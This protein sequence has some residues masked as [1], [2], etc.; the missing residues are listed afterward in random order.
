[1]W[2]KTLIAGFMAGLLAFTPAFSSITDQA[3]MELSAPSVIRGKDMTTLSGGGV[4][5]RI[6][7][8]TFRPF[9]IIPP[10]LRTGCGG[11]DATFGAFSY[12]NMEYL[13]QFLQNVLQ[14]APV[15]AFNL[16][17][18]TLCPQCEQL[19]QQLTAIANQINQ[20]G[21]TKCG[22]IQ[23][24]TSIGKH[25][26]NEAMGWKESSYGQVAP[27]QFGVLDKWLKA[28]IDFLNN[29][30]AGPL[31]QLCPQGNCVAG[32]MYRLTTQNGG[33]VSVVKFAVENEV[34]YAVRNLL[35]VDNYTLELIIRAYVGDVVIK[36]GTADNNMRS[37]SV[38]LF[39]PSETDTSKI[40]RDLLGMDITL[41][42]GGG[43]SADIN[44]CS[45]QG[46]I[47]NLRTAQFI[48]GCPDGQC[49][50]NLNL[51]NVRINS[52]CGQV[53][54]TFVKNIIQKAIN[55]QALSDQEKVLIASMPAPMMGL[56]N[57]GTVEPSI[58]EVAG[59]KMAKY[60]ATQLAIALIDGISRSLT[61][62][63]S[64]CL[65]EKVVSDQDK[66]ACMKFLDNVS[67][68]RRVMVRGQ[69][70]AMKEL[71]ESIATINQ[72]LDLQAKVMARISQSPLYGNFAFS[73]LVGG[74][75]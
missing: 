12:F 6:R 50:S 8:E 41:T 16:A 45:N 74:L 36:G 68:L 57:I 37:A 30:V 13:G 10:N 42:S 33:T 67:E 60:M 38:I 69:D 9:N 19:L 59:D 70:Q 52:L 32:L 25:L 20:I 40:L 39:P 15:I 14:A 55:R 27:D 47:S 5:F 11:I 22:A 29:Y 66:S 63:G 7:D 4:R 35:G 73:K 34:P 61:K 56:F 46:V 43:Q 71:N 31:Q 24:A 64:A 54:E 44:T 48:D 51:S 72:T 62:W 1:M 53:Y 17:L 49:F 65:S 58:L 21:A 23:L 28:P 75:R 18:H 3:I 26:I 2:G